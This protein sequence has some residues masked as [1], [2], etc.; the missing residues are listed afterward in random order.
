MRDLGSIR[1]LDDGPRVRVQAAF[2]HAMHTAFC[3]SC[4]T[5]TIR[6]PIEQR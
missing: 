2:E 1:L 3:K 6:R 5:M 4:Y